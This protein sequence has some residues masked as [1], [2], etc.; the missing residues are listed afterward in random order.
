[1]TA[2]YWLLVYSGRS[3]RGEPCSEKIIIAD[4][5]RAGD[6]IKTDLKLGRL[7]ERELTAVWVSDDGHEG[8]HDLACVVSASSVTQS[9]NC[10]KQRLASQLSLRARDIFVEERSPSRIALW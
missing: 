10:A 4:L 6:R 1:M 3:Y 5:E 2:P 8:T 9:Q 7:R